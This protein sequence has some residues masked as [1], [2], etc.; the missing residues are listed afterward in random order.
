MGNPQIHERSTINS[1]KS[2][3]NQERN[4]KI[5]WETKIKMH[6]KTRNIAKTVIRKI[7]SDKYL[8]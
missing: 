2:K 5:S 7:Y 6:T 3:K 1:E 4:F 8:H